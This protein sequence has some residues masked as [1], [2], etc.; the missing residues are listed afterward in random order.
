MTNYYISDLHIGHYNI[1]GFDNRPFSS[2]EEMTETLILNWNSVV[3]DDDTVYILGDFIWGKDST[4]PDIV[5][6]FNGKK[7][8][9]RGNHDPKEFNNE[10]RKLFADIKDYMEITDSEK[11][12]IMC[13]YPI[14]F[15]K[16]DYGENVWMLYG[17]VHN[18][19]EY[20]YVKG[21]RSF[22]KENAHT[23]VSPRG[24]FINVGCMMPWMNYTPRML[25]EIIEGDKKFRLSQD[26]NPVENRNEI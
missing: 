19:K 23:R 21:I 17:H 12:V 25:E 11:H 13:H 15:H 3:A 16:S 7:V 20:E 22:I 14:P 10:T 26:N 5:R 1:I 18:T 9:I 8:L 4:W 6:R 24:N 2:C